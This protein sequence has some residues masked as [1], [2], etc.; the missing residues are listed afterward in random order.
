MKNYI[1]TQ[2]KKK[3][4]CNY[5]LINKR[6]TLMYKNKKVFLLKLFIQNNRFKAREKIKTKK[7]K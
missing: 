6:K 7:I 2:I 4:K 5:K 3:K 1:C